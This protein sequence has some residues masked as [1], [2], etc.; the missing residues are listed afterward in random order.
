MNIQCALT[1]SF[2]NLNADMLARQLKWAYKRHAA[3]TAVIEELSPK[4]RKMGEWAYYDAV[5]AAAGG[6]T[7][8]N[9]LTSGGILKN[10][11]KN[12][13]A[14][15]KNR[16]AKII[17]ALKKVGVTEIEPFELVHTSDGCEGTFDIDGH[18]VTIKTILAGGYNIQ[19][20]H[21][22]T[23]VKVS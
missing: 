14:I 17:A 20:L 19:C 4:R 23:T 10:V 16:D 8:F 13:D 6:K 12:V 11:T 15:I 22:R 21:Q 1:Y 7:W 18:R 9:L 3:V 5:F 2:A